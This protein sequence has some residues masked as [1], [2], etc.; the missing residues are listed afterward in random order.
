MEKFGETVTCFA[1]V[2]LEARDLELSELMVSC[3][4]ALGGDLHAE[5][6]KYLL[7][8]AEGLTSLAPSGSTTTLDLRCLRDALARLKEEKQA[9][10]LPSGS[11]DSAPVL[12]PETET[13]AAEAAKSVPEEVAASDGA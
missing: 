5:T 11:C 7:S 6:V 3:L 13:E 2:A 9:E 12:R 1:L 8:D 10:L 4:E